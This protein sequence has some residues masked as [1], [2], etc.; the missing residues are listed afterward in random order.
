MARYLTLWWLGYG[1][2]A[3]CSITR[4]RM[5]FSPLSSPPRPDLRRSP[6]SLL[7]NGYRG[8]FPQI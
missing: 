8:I 7:S 3:G 5:D 2:Y 6:P 1:L 4:R